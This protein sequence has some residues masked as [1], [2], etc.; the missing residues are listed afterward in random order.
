[1]EKF[2]ETI[3][4]YSLNLAVDRLHESIQSELGKED[5]AVNSM[6]SAVFEKGYDRIKSEINQS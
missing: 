4:S 5:S 3:F 2:F 1:M 6:L